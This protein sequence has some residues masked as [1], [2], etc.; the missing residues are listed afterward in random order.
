V[1][2]LDDGGDVHFPSPACVW[3]WLSGASCRRHSS[4]S[5][6]S[7]CIGGGRRSRL[8]SLTAVVLQLLSCVGWFVWGFTPNSLPS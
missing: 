8:F 3:W 1:T 4:V 6:C 2:G 5:G 7:W